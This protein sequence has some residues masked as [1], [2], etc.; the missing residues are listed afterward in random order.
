MRR[1]C[2]LFPVWL[3]AAWLGL[4][5]Q[6]LGQKAG[7]A[8]I[9]G[10]VTDESGNPVPFA[11]IGVDKSGTGTM[12][13]ENGSY[14]LNLGQGEWT[15]VFHCL[16]Y[17]TVFRNIRISEPGERQE[18]AVTL[19]EQII[20]TRDVRV[21]SRAEDPAY[22]IMRKAIA[23]ARL[24]KL[25]VD[26]YEA[27]VYIKGSARIT[28][29][30][31]I[32]RGMAKK[33]GIDE[34]TV[35]FLETI[36]KLS[37]RQ[38]GQYRER[39]VASRSTFGNLHVQQNFLKSDL[40]NPEY[41]GTVSPL[42]PQAL[43]YYRFQ[44]LGSFQ[45]RGHEVFKIKVSAR[46]PQEGFWEGDLFILD[47]YWGLHSARLTRED[48][49]SRVTLT[50][51]YAPVDG[52]WM[53]MQN[54]QEVRGKALGMTIEGVY[55]SQVR[56]YALTRNA[57]LEESFRVLEEQLEA[58]AAE[59]R[60]K[61]EIR[62]KD[63]R[64]TDREDKKALRK[65]ARAILK[66][67]IRSR[68]KTSASPP[69]APV[70][71]DV[72]YQIDSG[73]SGKDSLFWLENRA[74]PLTPMEIQ[75][76]FRLDS[77]R[78][79]GEKKDSA[80][81]KRNR[82]RSKF[83]LVMLAGTRKE[84]GK[85]DSLGRKPFRLKQFSPLMQLAFNAVEGYAMEESLWLQYF[86]QPSR[87]RLAD[88]RA[89]LQAGT[90]IR[91]SFA[92][93]RLLA[94][95]ILQ[96][97]R[98]G[99]EIQL[100]GGSAIRQINP[101]EPISP[102]LNSTMALFFRENFSKLYE[103]EFLRLGILKKLRGKLETEVNLDL[104]NRIPLVNA[105]LKKSNEKSLTFEENTVHMPYVPS[106]INGR[107]VICRFHALADWYPFLRSARYNLRQ[108]F[109][110]SSSPRIRFELV[111]AL[112]GI[113]GSSM[114]YSRVSVSLRHLFD[115]SPGSSLETFARSAF[116]LNRTRY[117]QMDVLHLLGNE[118]PFLPGGGETG[119]FRTLPYYRMSGVR[120]V[121]EGHLQLNRRSLIL[122]W[123][124]ARKRNWRELLIARGMA[125]VSQPSFYEFGY[126]IDQLLRFFR[127]EVLYSGFHGKPGF[128]SLRVGMSTSLR[129]APRTFNREPGVS[130]GQ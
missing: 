64:R 6:G 81:Q 15:V 65:L 118:T 100:S 21:L 44:Y 71:S 39:V 38:P 116:F 115:L 9:Y 69:P 97:A 57:R 96:Y 106:A 13:A 22:A 90:N 19:R 48:D 80:Q 25:R 112:P 94:S 23:R 20:Q 17:E 26:A 27:D 111:Q 3:A 130:G 127:A 2:F 61:P 124:V 93:K 10:K 109:F 101:D 73:A 24:N 60:Q 50:Q 92:R 54:K 126:G 88:T 14:E 46:N 55:F 70:D 107:T 47:V 63:L 49:D 18:Q 87:S 125:N 28:R 91:Y 29:L 95:G 7:F 128:W 123:L 103:S 117:G 102:S 67:K 30:P 74:V 110:V 79:E 37:F 105:S 4:S 120:P 85:P 99:W 34:N 104:E 52:V 45:D 78:R 89:Y 11:T 72:E 121:F 8:G 35:F 36:E 40:Y 5:L 59:A 84:W 122:G 86:P 119:H 108:S 82:A 56:R 33:Q 66:E 12:A 43:R 16:G 53:L 98:P 51:T 68:K 76:Y 114:D 58:R 32:L 1:N 41:G 31:A 129:L 62:E 83:L 42:S 77:L 113:L 75:S